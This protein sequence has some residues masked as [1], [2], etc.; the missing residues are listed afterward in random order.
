MEIELRM[1]VCLSFIRGCRQRRQKSNKLGAVIFFMS[2]SDILCTF[3]ISTVEVE[4]IWN[5]QII[6]VIYNIWIRNL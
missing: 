4:E 5:I 2:M 3:A 1:A 6:N